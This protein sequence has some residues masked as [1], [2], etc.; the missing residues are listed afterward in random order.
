MDPQFE[1]NDRDL[2]FM[3]VP[4]SSKL[5]LQAAGSM[6]FRKYA[7]SVQTTTIMDTL[8]SEPAQ[9]EVASANFKPIHTGTWVASSSQCPPPALES[10]ETY[11]TPKPGDE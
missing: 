9:K 11:P 10:I 4:P 5:Y 1:F 8:D 2:V 7:G 6:V 3:R